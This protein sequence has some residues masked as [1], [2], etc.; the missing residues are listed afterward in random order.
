MGAINLLELA[1]H[2]KGMLPGDSEDRGEKVTAAKLPGQWL[3]QDMAR[4]NPGDHGVAAKGS[5]SKDRTQSAH[6]PEMRHDQ[7][8]AGVD[9]GQQL[10]ASRDAPPRDASESKGVLIRNPPSGPAGRFGGGDRRWSGI[11]AVSRAG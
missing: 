6:V 4:N 1:R 2:A 9:T 3:R 5:V 8:A 10:I 11:V 7:K